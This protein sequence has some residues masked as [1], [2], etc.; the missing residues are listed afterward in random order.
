MRLKRFGLFTC[1]IKQQTDIVQAG[2]QIAL[3]I[4]HKRV[5]FGQTF[6]CRKSLFERLQGL[7]RLARG[8][9]QVSKIDP[10]FSQF[11]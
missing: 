10:G 1:S 3:E 9:E 6:I 2:G 4:D 8:S 7:G 5:G 11:G